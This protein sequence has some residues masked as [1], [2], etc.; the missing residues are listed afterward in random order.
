MS[1]LV[2]DLETKKSFD[3]VGGRDNFHLLEVSLVGVYNYDNNAFLTFTERELGALEKLLSQTNRV[4]GFNIKNFD[5]TVLQPYVSLNL[6]A[7]PTLDILEEVAR[8]LGF[9][10][11]LDSIAAA[12][13]GEKKTGDGLKALR[14]YKEGKMQELADYCLQ[15]VKLTITDKPCG[16]V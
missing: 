1:E 12:T 11:K 10:V 13:L 7:L 3:E 8:T 4:V 16:R 2:L 6:A 14:L 9:R 5:F 15:D